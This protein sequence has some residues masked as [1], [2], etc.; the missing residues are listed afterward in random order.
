MS[1]NNTSTPEE[2][3]VFTGVQTALYVAAFLISLPLFIISTYVRFRKRVSIERTE[4][5][6]VAV[7]SV[8][9]VYSF[10]SSFHWVVL[11]DTQS[12]AT[13]GCT[14][15]AVISQYNLLSLLVAT[16][17]IGVHLLLLLCQPKCLRVIEEQK[18]QRYKYFEILYIFLIIFMP[19]IL[20]PWPF[21]EN[22]YGKTGHLCWIGIN[23]NNSTGVLSGF[24]EQI[25]LY[26]LWSFL[27]FGF[28]TIV[29]IVIIFTI[30][31]HTARKWSANIYTLLCYI[32]IFV[33]V[34]A[35]GLAIRV[36][37]WMGCS[38][39][40]H[41]LEHVQSIIFPLRT[42]LIAAV[43]LIRVCYIYRNFRKEYKRLIYI[44]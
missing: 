14:A 37:N 24:I 9:L 5:Q 31:R 18:R 42:G 22:L 1:S 38:A 11:F 34:N 25:V 21:I 44:N 28:T 8:L 16:T 7:G 26:Y 29:T 36:C 2:N 39:H 41:R 10:F 3:L 32:V 27:V 40:S 12:A 20:L 15:V 4:T 35:I 17:C 43:L 23:G 33:I 30:C 13:A 6:F 19:L